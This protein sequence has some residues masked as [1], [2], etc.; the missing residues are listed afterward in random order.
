VKKSRPTPSKPTGYLR[1]QYREMDRGEGLG[2]A[3][4]LPIMA[5]P[6]IPSATKDAMGNP[7]KRSKKT[8]EPDPD[9]LADLTPP[10]WLSEGA[11][12][13]WLQEAPKFRKARLLTEIDV[14]A[15]AALCQAA[16]DYRRA[17]AKTGED[18]VKV[19]MVVDKESGQPVSTG[20]HLNPWAMVKSM[21]SKQMAGWLGKFGGTP[22]D[23]T[24]VE[25][26]PQAELFP[27]DAKKDKSEA[28][29]H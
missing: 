16:S 5:R 14:L 29:F 11:R 27:S 15:F 4:D 25:L 21:A 9:Y 18:D 12:V 23:R 19:K 22:Q 26:N 17:V 6:K 7:G 8:K 13:V 3:E 24:R 28:Y 10:D 1:A 2:N 20:E